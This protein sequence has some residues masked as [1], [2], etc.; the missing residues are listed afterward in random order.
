[1]ILIS[2]VVSLKGIH[3]ELPLNKATFCSLTIGMKIGLN[4]RRGKDKLN[5]ISLIEMEGIGN[6]S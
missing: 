2:K 6:E 1:M 3:G 5:V 4:N